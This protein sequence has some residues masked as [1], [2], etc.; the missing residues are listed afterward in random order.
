M[1]EI[2]VMATIHPSA[3]PRADDR[4]AAYAGLVADLK[5]AADALAK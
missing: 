5:I 3:V 1:P 4:D 2:Q